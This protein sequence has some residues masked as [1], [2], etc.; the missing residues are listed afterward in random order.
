MRSIPAGEE[1]SG[2]AAEGGRLAR[3]FDSRAVV[4]GAVALVLL[5]G[6]FVLDLGYYAPRGE[7]SGGT[8]VATGRDA[9]LAR[10]RAVVKIVPE[11]ALRPGLRP[12]LADA[13]RFFGL[14]EEVLRCSALATEGAEE[15]DEPNERRLL[16]L[17]RQARAPGDSVTLCLD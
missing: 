1:D 9:E 5:A 13:I 16:A 12:T 8:A 10:N 4:L 7:I 14:E 2:A 11:M 6:A 15:G 17:G 3:S